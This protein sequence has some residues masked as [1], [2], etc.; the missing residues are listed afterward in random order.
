[1]TSTA[2]MKLGAAALLVVLASTASPLVSAPPAAYA[3]TTQDATWE[4]VCSPATPDSGECQLL[5][6]TDLSATPASAVTAG[7]VPAGYGRAD[8]AS[9]YGLPTGSQGSGMTVAVVDSYDQPSAESDLA[10]YRSHYGLSPCTTANGCFRKVDQNGETVS[11][12]A[13]NQR[14]GMESDLDI[15][16]VSAVCPNCNILLVEAFSTDPVDQGMAA[17]TAV[18]L[19]AMAV[20]N[21][22]SNTAPSGARTLYSM[23]YDHPGVA[24][25]ASTGDH[26]SSTAYPASFPSVIAVGGTRLE[27]DA[28]ARGWSETAWSRTGGGCTA[29]E[30]KPGWQ[31]DTGC[32][33]RT[34]ADV[35]AVADTAT[36]VAMYDGGAGGWNVVGGTSVSAPIV[37]S[38]YALAGRPAAGT[39][40][41]SYLYANPAGLN[42]VTTGSNGSCGTYLCNAGPGFDGPTGLGTPRGLASFKAPTTVP[43]TPRRPHPVEDFTGDGNAD[44]VSVSAAGYLYLYPH[45]P[46]GFGTSSIIGNGW[47]GMTAIIAGDFNGDGNADVVSRSSA[48][49]LYLYPHTPSGF[50]T[51]SIIGN[52]W[53]GMTAIIAGDFNGD[54][55]DDIVSRDTAGDLWLYPHTPSGFGAQTKI[56][57]GWNG[58]TYIL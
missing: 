9:A 11:F 35:S 2:G 31:H 1:M 38:I 39:N 23:F 44:I 58:M 27:R 47:N 30:P 50:G 52:G 14:W 46:S 18:S 37:A 48:G 13:T 51:S 8:L 22:Y 5:V 45:K 33:T 7:T 43:P 19:G 41:A 28:S 55:N 17:N 54:G 15:E 32:A 34:E 53:N 56:G 49:N 42:D 40:P 3:D 25:T 29:T 6:R 4:S 24:I 36:G 10:V 20:S 12:P 26:G 57:N 21:S 16:M